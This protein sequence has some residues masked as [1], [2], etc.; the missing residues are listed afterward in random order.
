MLWFKRRQTEKR[1]SYDDAVISALF[2]SADTALHQRGRETAV[3]EAAAGLVQRC[4]SMAVPS[5]AADVLTPACLGLM[6]RCLLRF[7]ES[8]HEIVVRDGMVYL[9]PIGSW[10]VRGT[11]EIPTTWF[12]RCDSWGPDRGRHR[13]RPADAVL[14]VRYSVDPVRPWQ[15]ISPLQAAYDSGR[16]VGSLEQA[17]ADESGTARGYVIPTSP[18]V[19]G[20]GEESSETEKLRAGLATMRGRTTVAESTGGN[21]FPQGQSGPS[22]GDWQARRIGVNVPAPVVDLRRQ[23]EVSVAAALG[24]PAGLLFGGADASALREQFRQL[25][26]STIAPMARCIEHEASEKLER[27]ITLSLDGLNAA[28]IQGRARAFDSLVKG[29]MDQNMAASLAGM[30]E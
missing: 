9:V 14:H 23:V 26:H 10:D 5:E 18:A 27:D 24:V 15:G 25:L 20:Q 6:A 22:P 16:L 12:Y 28:D 13:M 19:A 4:M 7:G 8:L 1:A 11:S 29:G 21:P 30:T 3:V 17:I 2:Q